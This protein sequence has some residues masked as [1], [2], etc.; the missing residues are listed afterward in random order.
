MSLK[1]IYFNFSHTKLPFKIKCDCRFETKHL[2]ILF[3]CL[4]V[5]FLFL[6]PF[7]LVFCCFFLYVFLF[8]FIL[9]YF[10]LLK[11]IKF[12]YFWN[13]K[14]ASSWH[15]DIIK[16]KKTTNK[17]RQSLTF[18]IYLKHPKLNFVIFNVRGDVKSPILSCGCSYFS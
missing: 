15:N 17:I 5:C 2:Y 3:V 4:F 14:F 1:I 16:I 6:F 7:F 11:I 13:I 10:I 12:T 8:V 9:F 18:G